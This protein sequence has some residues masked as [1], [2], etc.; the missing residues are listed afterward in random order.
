MWQPTDPV[1]DY[2]Y[3]PI[4]KSGSFGH[5]IKHG[6]TTF[7]EPEQNLIYTSKEEQVT[8]L[9]KEL[10]EKDEFF[11]GT[12]KYRMLQ[13]YTRL[14]AIDDERDPKPEPTKLTRAEKLEI[15]PYYLKFSDSDSN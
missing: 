13:H 14:A 5:R 3:M 2:H 7:G 15:N 1:E 9:F 11:P 4:T 12:A 8:R 10:K 6:H